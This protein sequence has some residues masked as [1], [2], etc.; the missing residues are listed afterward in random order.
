MRVFTDGACSNNGKP[1]AK[2]G[3]AIWFPEKRE[4]SCSQRL[5]D[6]EP[7]TNQRA[8]LSA[9]RMAVVILE[10]AGYLDEDI[11]IYTDSEYSMNCV[12]KWLPGWISR[13]WK[14]SDGKDVL[15]QDLIKEI[16]SILARFKSHRFVHVRAHTGGSDDLSRHNDIVDQMARGTIDESIKVVEPPVVDEIF[17][18]CPLRL[19]G[20]PTSQ[21]NILT[22]VR[23]NLSTLDKDIIDKHLM[24]AFVEVCKNRDINLTKQTIQRTPMFRAERG[25][26]Q[27]EHVVVEKIE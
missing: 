19:L 5:P 3:F 26:L 7:Q 18:G 8:E 25:H 17:P 2:A 1:D 13:N 11:V 20:P 16:T 6:N 10:K 27:I 15:H 23:E 21:P 9:I 14:T 12:G 4:L 24:K 22:W